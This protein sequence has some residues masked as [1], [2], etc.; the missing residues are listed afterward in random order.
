MIVYVGADYTCHMTIIHF[1]QKNFW[2]ALIHAY[3]FG[4]HQMIR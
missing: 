3:D 4:Q 1:V 2:Q